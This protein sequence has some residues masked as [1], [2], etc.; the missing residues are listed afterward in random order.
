LETH[1]LGVLR[2]VAGQ[3]PDEAP[4]RD[5]GHV[6]AVGQGGGM[7]AEARTARRE[8][9]LGLVAAE[10]D[11]VVPPRVAEMAEIEIGEA[12]LQF[13]GRRACDLSRRCGPD[14]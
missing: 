10:A 7:R 13:R 8:L 4:V 14:H 6:S 9:L 2:L 5:D 1:D 3:R 11:M 12:A